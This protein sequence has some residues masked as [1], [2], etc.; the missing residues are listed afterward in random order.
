[1]TGL[2]RNPN[3][4]QEGKRKHT[5]R[6]PSSTTCS[7]CKRR[8]WAPEGDAICPYCGKRVRI[9]G[10]IVGSP[11]AFFRTY[12]EGLAISGA[13]SAIYV[14][15]PYLRQ[16]RRSAGPSDAYQ[17]V[18]S[19]KPHQ[20]RATEGQNHEK[21]LQESADSDSDRREGEIE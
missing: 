21:K 5:R 16:S 4:H 15:H 18:T 3:D 11:G 6:V 2:R 19:E 20:E 13:I 1:M 8:F 9:E 10:G 12:L 7:Y 14:S 17:K